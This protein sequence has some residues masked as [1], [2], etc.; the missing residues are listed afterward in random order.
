MRQFVVSL[1]AI[2]VLLAGMGLGAAAQS[3]SPAAV[4]YRAFT[5]EVRATDVD[6][7]GGESQYHESYARKS[8]GS[9]AHIRETE[10]DVGER[11]V[12]RSIFDAAS[13]SF[14]RASSFTKAAITFLGEQEVRAFQ[15]VPGSCSWIADGTWKQVGESEKLG[16]H[17]LEVE[18]VSPNQT[19]KYWV[20]PELDCFPLLD[21]VIQKGMVRTKEE[22]ISIEFGDPDPSAFRIPPGYVEVSPLQYEELWKKKYGRS[23][24]GE[25]QAQTL[26][27]KYQE[28]K[29]ARLKD[30]GSVK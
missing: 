29:A 15:T 3:A 6:A 9:Y 18:L 13:R 20:A 24:Y 4:P 8:D 5:A 27:R 22:V 10:N 7:D 14:T 23:Y 17:V 26:E 11:G 21:V 12:A 1:I 19:H 2:S 28:G 25:E 16:M 30:S